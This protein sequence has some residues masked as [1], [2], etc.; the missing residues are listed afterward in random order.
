[1][2]GRTGQN[3]VR[4]PLF[5]SSNGY[6]ADLQTAGLCHRRPGK[7]RK[8]RDQPKKRYPLVRPNRLWQ[9]QFIK[10]QTEAQQSKL[11]LWSSCSG[12]E[13]EIAPIVPEES[14]DKSCLIKGNISASGEKIYHL[15]GCGSYKNTKIDEARE[16][17][18][19]CTEAEALVAGW[20]KALNCP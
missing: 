11:G 13:S 9:D 17:R 8:A 19:F 5:D 2:D 16:E 6:R 1:M 3:P 14:A 4:E 15:P 7:C 10:A 18:W 12:S 20:R